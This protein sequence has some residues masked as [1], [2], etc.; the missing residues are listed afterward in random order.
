MSGIDVQDQIGAALDALKAREFFVALDLARACEDET[1]RAEILEARALQGLGA[2][3]AALGILRGLPRRLSCNK[4][5][6][7]AYGVRGSTYKDAASRLHGEGAACQFRK[8]AWAYRQGERTNVEV[9][10]H[11]IN[12]AALH[13][14]LGERD[15]AHEIATVI[16]ND[17]GTN[18]DAWETA[19]HAEAL[20]LLER[21]D[22]A[23]PLYRR[24]S[25]AARKGRNWFALEAYR[26]NP[27]LFLDTT[28]EAWATLVGITHVPPV[29]QLVGHI[30]DAPGR[31]NPRFPHAQVPIVTHAISTFLDRNEW[32]LAVSGAAAG[33]DLLFL[34]EAR[35]RDIDT[36][37]VLPVRGDWYETRSVRGF[38]GRDWSRMHA[39]ALASP[40]MVIEVTKDA[41]PEEGL[42]FAHAGEVLDGLVASRARTLNTDVVRLAVWDGKGASG[43]G[44]TGDTIA[45]WTSSRDA[46]EIHVLRIDALE[47]GFIQ[48][49]AKSNAL[50]SSR[51]AN[52]THGSSFISS[53]CFADVKGYSKLS[54][55]EVLTFA[56]EVLDPIAKLLDAAGDHVIHANTWGDAVFASFSSVEHAAEFALSLRD[57]FAVSD[58]TSGVEASNV[59]NSLPSTSRLLERLHIRVG[60]HAAPVYC[61]HDPILK[62]L[63]VTGAAIS[64]AA[65]I[66]PQVPDNQVYA[67]ASFV[68]VLHARGIRDIAETYVGQVEL[69]KD[70]GTFPTYRI[71]RA[72]SNRSS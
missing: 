67:S 12:L 41:F 27:R 6:S 52:R 23:W 62:K 21:F 7:E 1:G 58:A 42:A 43:A 8:A 47:D 17:T 57:L 51:V 64:H 50:P 53:L 59:D 11:R 69:A 18:G 16:V 56:T 70:F 49:R 31:A 44:G 60:L 45:R 24:V 22:E 65:R 28:G 15:I 30:V 54:E 9:N 71:E 35:K 26:R 14:K 55:R 5:T 68:G 10:W 13:W 63:R 2:L 40:S 37:I 32:S 36:A 39:A 33:A 25:D 46:G 72:E 61:V 29:V 38:E 66:E 20:L 34:E 48:Y 3:D 19:T 4:L